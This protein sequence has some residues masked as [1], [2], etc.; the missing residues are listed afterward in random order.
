LPAE[1][2]DAILVADQVVAQRVAELPAAGESSAPH[3]SQPDP[4][5]VEAAAEVE[6]IV[7]ELDAEAIAEEKAAEERARF[8]RLEQDVLIGKRKGRW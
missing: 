2:V 6:P 7:E 1:Q 5:A 8:A 4:V 3:D